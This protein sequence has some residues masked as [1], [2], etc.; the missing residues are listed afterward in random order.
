MHLWQLLLVLDL[1]A[2]AKSPIPLFSQVLESIRRGSKGQGLIP[3]FLKFWE[4]KDPG[5]LKGI[6]GENLVIEFGTSGAL[7][8][9]GWSGG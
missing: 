4:Q 7:A 5:K 1:Q 2:E 8:P 6:H 3:S 9:R